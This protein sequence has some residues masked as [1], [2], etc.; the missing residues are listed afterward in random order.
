MELRYPS[1]TVS[2]VRPVDISDN[3]WI[4]GTAQRVADNT[5]HQVLLRPV[6]EPGVLA[7]ELAAGCLLGTRRT[8]GKRAAVR[9]YLSGSH[10]RGGWWRGRR[11]E[12]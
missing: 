4:P 6:L 2:G 10:R 9:W 1:E 11:R 12:E 8:R 7:M 3:G 5:F